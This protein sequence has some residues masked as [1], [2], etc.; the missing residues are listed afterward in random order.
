MDLF[1]AVRLAVNGNSVLFL[2]AGASWGAKDKS[3]SQLPLGG[4]L[5][6][7]IA[8]MCKLPE[9]TP[10][11]QATDIF[12]EDFS[13]T[14]LIQYLK[15]RIE[16]TEI[17][18]HHRQLAL[19]N[20]MSVYTTNY[21]DVYE[22]ACSK[23]GKTIHRAVLSQRPESVVGK[24]N[25][26][27]HINGAIS[28]LG[29]DTLLSEFK[30]TSTSYLTQHFHES[31]WIDKFRTD[32]RLAD[33]VIF[34]GYSMYD[35][36][37]QRIVF[38]TKA[39]KD[40]TFFVVSRDEPVNN[41]RILSRF[42]S[43][44]K[45]GVEYF[46][47]IVEKEMANQIPTSAKK[48]PL[49]KWKKSTSATLAGR[50][51]TEKDVESLLLWGNFSEDVLSFVARTP[52]ENPYVFHRAALETIA[53]DI[54]A[55]AKD[56]VVHSHLGNGKSILQQQLKIRLEDEG[57]EV[58]E[59]LDGGKE[60]Q[61]EGRRIV[62]DAVVKTVLIFPE[63]AGSIDM[64]NDLSVHRSKVVQFLLF[65]RTSS[66]DVSFGRLRESLRLKLRERGVNKLRFEDIDP[67]V[68]YLDLYAYWGDFAGRTALQKQRIIKEQ[69]N[70]EVSS[71]LM[72]LLKSPAIAA[73]LNDVVKAFAKDKKLMEALIA[74]M[75]FNS[76]ALEYS[77]DTLLD[78]IDP[79]LQTKLRRQDNNSI[80]EIIDP[81]ENGVKARSPVSARFMLQNIFPSDEVG[82]V[83]IRLGI[84]AGNRYEYRNVLRELARYKNI[85]SMLPEG[86]GRRV[87][88]IRFYESVKRIKWLNNTPH[89][90]MQ[91]AVA[92]LAFAEQDSAELGF[93][94]RYFETSYAKADAI[95]GYD[96]NMIDNHYARYLLMEAQ[97][98]A[99]ESKWFGLFT[100]AAK[101]LRSQASGFTER[102]YPYRVA[103]N[104]DDVMSRYANKITDSQ[105]REIL[106]F[107]KYMYKASERLPDEIAEHHSVRDFR[108]RA[109][110][111]LSMYDT[112]S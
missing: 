46:G 6:S 83:L 103:S 78:L 84:A 76:A 58:I 45:I 39:I 43:V 101:I 34:V 60:A 16:C 98:P 107:C 53:H 33:S 42:G 71:L 92:R 2:G 80:K 106:D 40:K 94:K 69:C 81:E 26:C 110:R 52:E 104:I 35:L 41:V 5:A 111:L 7:E 77:A 109:A 65:S 63:Y 89:F 85:Q 11:D 15:D 102:H 73:R 27:I 72:L 55:D 82:K 48:T 57:F 75:I 47:T 97:I 9:D 25:V 22:V 50:P 100:E 38:A 95:P 62:E 67:I 87:L 59:L 3:G 30:L 51:A 70:L 74:I 31:Q 21:D 24:R 29:S 14:E 56:V 64:V 1:E 54:C 44:E 28:N 93:A 112:A 61:D 19:P 66:N 91:Y 17:A 23:H 10:L 96:T 68:S 37:I 4:M 90:W 88:A 79:D 36:D 99:N 86:D 18:N 49:R 13:A 12:L 108:V 8:T 20:W 105:R 32:L